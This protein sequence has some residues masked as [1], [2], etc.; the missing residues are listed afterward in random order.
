MGEDLVCKL[1][2]SEDL[3]SKFSLVRINL[4]A[5]PVDNTDSIEEG[6]DWRNDI[7]LVGVFPHRYDFYLVYYGGTRQSC[8]SSCVKESDFVQE[9]VAWK[10]RV[11][12]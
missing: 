11:D 12:Y 1:N 3:L 2:A 6:I 5:N 7:K 4:D 8:S 9:C 10:E